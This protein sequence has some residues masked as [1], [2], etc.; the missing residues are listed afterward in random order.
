MTN[1][2]RLR[3]QHILYANILASFAFFHNPKYRGPDFSWE[4]W[5]ENCAD[6]VEVWLLVH[7]KFVGQDMLRESQEFAKAVAKA[8]VERMCE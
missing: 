7:F 8:S 4:W 3:V 5:V 6:S 2:E 1:R